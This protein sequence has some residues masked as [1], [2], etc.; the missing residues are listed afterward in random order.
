VIKREIIE[1]EAGKEAC[2][3]VTKAMKQQQRAKAKKKE[4]KPPV[5]NEQP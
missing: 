1:S 3:Q 2:K 4:V 5:N